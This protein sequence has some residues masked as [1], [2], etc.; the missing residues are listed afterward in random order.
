MAQFAK[1]SVIVLMS[2][3]MVTGVATR[4]RQKVEPVVS[5]VSLLISLWIIVACAVW[6]QP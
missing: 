6:W 1:W 4:A 5:V 2:L 3:G